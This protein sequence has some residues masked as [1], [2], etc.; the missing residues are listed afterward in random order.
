MRVL[1][2][3]PLPCGCGL[4][5]EVLP[6][7]SLPRKLWN[8]FVYSLLSARKSMQES[9]FWSPLA[10]RRIITAMHAFDP[11]LVVYDTVRTGQYLTRA[12]GRRTR[13]ILY[14]DDL[15]SLRYAR[16]LAAERKFHL[17]SKGAL[18]NFT[19]KLP[20]V[21]VKV[22]QSFGWLRSLLLKVEM[23]L[24]SK[25]ENE[26]P[27][28][29]NRCLLVSA[30]E[31]DTLRRRT[32]NFNIHAIPPR[33]EPLASP[34][35]RSWDGNADFVFLGSLNLS[36]NA[37]AIEHFIESEFASIERQ[38]PGVRILIVGKDAS[39]NLQRL[40][41]EHAGQVQ[42]MGFVD[43]LSEVLGQACAMLSPLLFGSGLKIKTVEALRCGIPI[44]TTSIGLEGTDLAGSVGVRVENDLRR[45][46][47]AMRHFLSP[48]VNQIASEAN[49]Q[50]FYRL[51]GQTIT[52]QIY[53]KLLLDE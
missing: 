9:F 7:P 39:E 13:H 42:L 52:D 45:F 37:F 31:A 19:K 29:F 24:I 33:F 27:V 50:A 20:S 14:M 34:R 16:L 12:S 10:R 41:K 15:F 5:A 46:S 17:G 51:Y 28:R 1:C 25:I 38:V 2:F 53:S 11:D 32:G 18:G 22:F 30:A 43:D 40:A 49:F 47:D 35:E 44:I 23:N 21:F 26:C 4:E 6:S 48:E 36:H 3:E 8:I